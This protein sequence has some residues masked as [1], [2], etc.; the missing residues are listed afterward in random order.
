M[1]LE[2]IYKDWWGQ[3]S[4]KEASNQQKKNY[5]PPYS[6]GY[7]E[8]KNLPFR[9]RSLNGELSHAFVYNVVDVN[10]IATAFLAKPPP[11]INAQ[12]V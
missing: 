7:G 5:T 12:S 4:V 2:N 11:Y 3:Q 1:L 10:K 8:F 9:F 6:P